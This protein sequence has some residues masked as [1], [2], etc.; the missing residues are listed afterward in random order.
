LPE[1]LSKATKIPVLEAIDAMRIEPNRV[2]VMPSNVIVAGYF[3]VR[4]R[5]VEI[6]PK[7]LE[8][9]LASPVSLKKVINFGIL[10]LVIQMIG[11]LAVRWLGDGGVLLLSVIGGT[12]SSASTT[13][14]VANLVTHGNV[15]ALQAGTATI[16]TSIASTGMNLPIVRRQI[17]DKGVVREIMLAAGLQTAVGI[18]VL[19]F[20][21]WFIR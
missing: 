10:F 19:F 13:A 2:Y 6:D 11:T 1:L 15:S 14:A 17:R 7:E 21:K 5:E 3:A 9:H 18:T 16:L 12:A 4:H 8:L 20:E